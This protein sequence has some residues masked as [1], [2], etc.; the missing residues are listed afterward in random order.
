MPVEFDITLTSDDMYR[1]NM[2][3]TYSGFHGI[4]SI[5]IAIF[6]FVM[7][8]VTFGQA[9]LMYTVIYVIFGI[10]FLFYSPVTLY[11]HAKR[12]IARSEVLSKPL[13]YHV[14]EKNGFTVS[15][16][17]ESANLPWKQIYKMVATKSNV[18]VYSNRTN[19][20]V[21]PRAQ[22]GDN[23]EALAAL[24]NKQLEKFRVKMK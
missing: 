20:Y 19:A 11:L 18:L 15:Q 10:V 21:I 23:Y 9:E 1:F 3:Q 5:V 2:Y 24:A 8:A 6:I 4:F 22:L 12:N 13:H 16:D 14:D 17:G 7:A